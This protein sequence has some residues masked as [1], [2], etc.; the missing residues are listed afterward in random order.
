M[1]SGQELSL[2]CCMTFSIGSSEGVPTE[3]GLN[4]DAEA[5]LQFAV[6]HP[7]WELFANF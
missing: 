4:K 1:V 2:R 5:V 6:K 7:K 3:E